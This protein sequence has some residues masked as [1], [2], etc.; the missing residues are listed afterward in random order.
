MDNKKSNLITRRQ[1][2]VSLATIAAGTLIKPTSILASEVARSKTRFAIMGD[3][4]SGN[5]DG[6]GLAKQM[7]EV[8]QRT[9]LEFVIGA[10]DNIYPNGSGRHFAKNFEQPFAG[11]IKDEVKFY[12][13]LGN[14][15]IEDGRQDQLSYPLFN[16]GGSNYYTI[17][18][19]NGLVD[20]FMLDSTD[21]GNTQ[22]TWLE[23]S[24]RSS[25]A[26]WKVAVLHH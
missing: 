20:F 9:P 16:M 21:C 25:K 22:L 14:H 18:R 19:G 1:A 15:D 17:S 3:W 5:S 2:I 24:L 13:V 8:H 26:R 11:L 4:G 7:L 10:G 6:I 23:N 12:T